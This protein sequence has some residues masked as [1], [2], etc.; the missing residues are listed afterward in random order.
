MGTTCCWLEK[1]C[2][3]LQ[4]QEFDCWQST[5]SVLLPGGQATKVFCKSLHWLQHRWPTF[6]EVCMSCN[7]T[8]FQI[9]C[10][11]V[12]GLIW[13]LLFFKNLHFDWYMMARHLFLRTE[14]I[15]ASM[16]GS[17]TALYLQNINIIILGS[18][19]NIT[20][21]RAYVITEKRIEN[22]PHGLLYLL[23]RV[24]PR[25]WNLKW[26]SWIANVMKTIP[27]GMQWS[28]VLEVLRHV[29]IHYSKLPR[30][31]LHSR[32]KDTF[33]IEWAASKL[34]LRPTRST[35]LHKSLQWSRLTDNTQLLEVRLG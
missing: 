17:E 4:T 13:L 15:K 27:N 9:V 30:C 21:G 11:K 12:C 20:G 3:A 34:R 33:L 26:Q 1:E 7:G 19:M 22:L 23:R 35:R 8:P 2:D 25:I 5:N 24:K 6:F 18:I 14:T 29:H 32:G 16:C 28:V 10:T 31:L